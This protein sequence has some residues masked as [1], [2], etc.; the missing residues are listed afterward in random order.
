MD[1]NNL[2]LKVAGTTFRPNYPENLL[3]L[4]R[5]L[6]AEPESDIL[7]T[8]EEEPSNPYDPNAIKVILQ[9]TGEHLGYVPKGLT[10]EV[11]PFLHAEQ[12]Y[13]AIVYSVDIQR[14]HP[15]RPGLTI[16]VTL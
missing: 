15:D 2:L 1:Q 4:L 12:P 6:E 9:S 3:Q 13:T 11:K 10:E 14:N 8:L 7:L 16:G 5:G